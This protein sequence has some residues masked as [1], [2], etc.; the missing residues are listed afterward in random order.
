MNQKKLSYLI[1]KCGNLPAPGLDGIT[2]PF[3]KLEKKAAASMN[4][5]MMQLMFK[6]SRTADI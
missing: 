2:F 6:H 5:K 3:L 1:K 4:L